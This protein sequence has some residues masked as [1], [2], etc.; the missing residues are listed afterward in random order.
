MIFRKITAQSPLRLP[1]EDRVIGIVFHWSAGRYGVP[2]HDYHFCVDSD[3]TVYQNE[4]ADPGDKL[5]HTWNRNTGRVAISA[6]AMYNATE[7]NYGKYPITDKQIE[8]MSALAAKIAKQYSIPLNEIRTHADWATIDG[9]GPGSGDPETRWDLWREGVKLKA[10][11]QW[12]LK[13]LK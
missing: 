7:D 6:M 5:S 8:A 2:Y 3:G 1:A 11:T 4:E 12:Y 13:R 9:Y 10:K